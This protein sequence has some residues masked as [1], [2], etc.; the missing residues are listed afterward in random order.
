MSGLPRR[1][2]GEGSEEEDAEEE[3]QE[4]E[5]VAEDVEEDAEGETRNYKGGGGMRDDDGG[6]G[7]GSV[8]QRSVDGGVAFRRFAYEIRTQN[9]G[10][11]KAYYGQ[12]WYS[13]VSLDSIRCRAPLFA[14]F[15]ATE[16]E[17][18]S[19]RQSLEKVVYTRQ[20]MSRLDLDKTL[21]SRGSWIYN[22]HMAGS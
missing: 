14:P 7:G 19:W 12:A 17:A 9:T 1:G 13:I 11:A 22:H 16:V 3:E 4:D 21:R 10:A 6:G 5:E 18:T 8:A 2:G 15:F 20:S